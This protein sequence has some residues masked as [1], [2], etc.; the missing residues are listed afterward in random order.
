MSKKFLTGFA[1]TALLI[2]V[3]AGTAFAGMTF[4]SLT[5]DPASAPSSQADTPK[6]NFT[7]SYTGSSDF[8]STNSDLEIGVATAASASNNPSTAPFVISRGFAFNGVNGGWASPITMFYLYADLDK[9][10]PGVS[11]VLIAR[12]TGDDQTPGNPAKWDQAGVSGLPQVSNSFCY[13]AEI[14]PIVTQLTALGENL[15]LQADFFVDG[16]EYV[17]SSAGVEKIK[18]TVCLSPDSKPVI[19]TELDTSGN[20]T[21]RARFVF[22]DSLTEAGVYD[23]MLSAEG[24]SLTK[25]RGAGFKLGSTL[26][27]F[28]F[29]PV[30]SDDDHASGS[31]NYFNNNNYFVQ[32][33]NETVLNIINNELLAGSQP[34]NGQ[35]QGNQQISAIVSQDHY[36]INTHS[37]DVHADTLELPAGDTRWAITHSDIIVVDNVERWAASPQIF[38]AVG[39][40]ELAAAM[41]AGGTEAEMADLQEN[42]DIVYQYD[43]RVGRDPDTLIGTGPHAITWDEAIDAGIARVD[44]NGTIDVKYVVVN[45][46]GHPRIVRNVFNGDPT[47]GKSVL[48]VFDGN[49]EDGK[50]LDPMWLVHKAEETEVQGQGH[51]GGC[52]AGLGALAI[53]GLAGAAALLRRKD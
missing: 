7:L 25:L 16:E 34:G 9:L 19:T 52:D 44:P 31:V 13:G 46:E 26:V 28:D 37:R 53:L 20:N 17:F 14:D 50:I 8:K 6:I 30:Q 45:G 21:N 11:Y 43:R 1:L 36:D 27:S 51:H 18:A 4:T 23:I 49:G 48:L 15:T 29:H 33:S 24:T 47:I 22:T 35:N 42:F 5:A 39:V 41:K 38:D 40:T 32:L 10:T 3:L 12:P 2:A